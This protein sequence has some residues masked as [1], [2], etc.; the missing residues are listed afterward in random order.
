[1]GARQARPISHDG[2]DHAMDQ[3]VEVDLHFH[4]TWRMRLHRR[5]DFDYPS[6]DKLIRHQG[7]A[8]EVVDFNHGACR[9]LGYTVYCPHLDTG[10]PN[11]GAL[12]SADPST[13][14]G[15]NDSSSYGLR[16]RV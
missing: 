7:L 15:S 4:N 1:M 3:Y 16:I 13:E 14:M 9:S 6:P 5:S 10:Q 11:R 2:S 12:E 8:E